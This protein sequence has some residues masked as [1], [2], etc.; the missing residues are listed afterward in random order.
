M[1][2]ENTMINISQTSRLQIKKYSVVQEITI[3][4]LMNDLGETLSG[5]P[6]SEKYGP[7]L[8]PVSLEFYN[9]L[10]KYANLEN[11]TMGEILVIM[12]EHLQAYMR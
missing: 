3:I 10:E 7:K 9:T 12:E 11:K 2:K 5:L 4:K 1:D 6:T 8:L